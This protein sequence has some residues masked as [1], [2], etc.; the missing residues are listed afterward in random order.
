[1]I[2]KDVGY[3]YERGPVGVLLLHGLG[4][5]PVE[6]KPVARGLA[7]AGLTVSA[8]VLAGHCG[9]EA[10]LLATGWTDW[11]ASAQSA[12]DALA[13]RCDKVIV[14]GLSMGAVL[15]LYTAARNPDRVAGLA[16][17]G[18]TL[19]YDGWAVPWYS[20]L[21]KGLI[22]L[23]WG[24]RYKFYEQPP[25]GIKDERMRARI[26]AAMQSGDSTQGGIDGTP[27][28]SLQQL[29]KLVG[30]VKAELPAI[31]APALILHAGNDDVATSRNAD[32][33][34]RHIGGLSEKILL[35]DSYHLI[36]IDQQRDDVIRHTV[37]FI[38]T[39]AGRG[40]ATAEAA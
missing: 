35:H 4:G 5:T 12:F 20:F 24:K 37:R 14:G 15:S 31:K 28:P 2:A 26:V 19:W 9:S 17:Y 39:L 21:L 32:Y 7:K 29:W 33:V 23:P 13:A 27:G 8:P 22:Y 6:L 18:T 1:M 34:E 3:L 40:N 25:Y 36:T 11:A 16:L 10:D 30:Q 38:R